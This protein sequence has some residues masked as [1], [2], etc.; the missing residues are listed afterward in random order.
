MIELKSSELD[1][2]CDDFDEMAFKACAWWPTIKE[3][4]QNIEPRLK[5]LLPFA[6]WIT[7][8]ADEPKTEEEV[9]S[10]KYLLNLIYKNVKIIYEDE[11]EDNA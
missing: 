8:T 11:E 6:L 2:I 7:E 9:Q 10:K 5:T 3:I 1:K 4:Q